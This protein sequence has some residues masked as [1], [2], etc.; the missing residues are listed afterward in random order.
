MRGLF[1]E[2]AYALLKDEFVCDPRGFVKGKGAIQ[3]WYL[4]G[5]KPA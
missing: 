5:P 2:G 1:A 4:L 3:T